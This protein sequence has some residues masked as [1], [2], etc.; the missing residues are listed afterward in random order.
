MC[1]S[2]GVVWTS[3]LGH[4]YRRHPLAII[5][6]L[7]DPIPHDQIRYPLRISSDDGWE[8]TQIWE[9]LPPEPE[10]GPPPATSPEDDLPPF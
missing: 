6:L 1:H 10:S 2:Y 4:R 7:P 5:E 9:Q 3:R 8:A